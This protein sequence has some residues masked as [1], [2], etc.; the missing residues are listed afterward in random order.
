MN[1]IPESFNFFW[2]LNFLYSQ[3]DN[4]GK[5]EQCGIFFTL[6]TKIK[7]R[8]GSDL[9]SAPSVSKKVMKLK[10]PSNETPRQLKWKSLYV[11]L[12]F[13]NIILAVGS[14]LCS[15]FK[16]MLTRVVVIWCSREYSRTAGFEAFFKW[17]MKVRFCPF[18]FVL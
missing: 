8:G 6:K 5:G 4:K 14:F 18:Y 12:D 1:K 13:H 15:R 7:E 11:N 16:C 9:S 2:F 10:L 3:T 17:K